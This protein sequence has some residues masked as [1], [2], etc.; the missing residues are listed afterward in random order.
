MTE[1]INDL[2]NKI[3]DLS[4]AG[5]AKDWQILRREIEAMCQ[6]IEKLPPDQARAM[7]PDLSILIRQLDQVITDM[8]G[9]K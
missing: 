7:L 8:A 1:D 3:D 5:T 6:K 2:Q 9:E 4:A